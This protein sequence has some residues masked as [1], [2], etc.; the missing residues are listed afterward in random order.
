MSLLAAAIVSALVVAAAI[1]WAGRLVAGEIKASRAAAS[2]ARSLEILTL[3][4]P[5]MLACINDPRTLL[6]WQPLAMTVRRLFPDECATLDAAAGATFPFDTNQLEAAHARW[7]ADW[8][9]WERAHDAE[10]KLKAAA[11]ESEMTVAGATPL[12]RAQLDAVEREKL[13]RY[14]RRYEEYVRTA[15]A[16]QALQAPPAR[17]RL[18]EAADL[19]E[20]AHVLDALL[21]S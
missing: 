13:E 14:Q 11:A 16:L 15:K 7:T 3:L 17:G 18:V 6:V 12:L 1:V 9:A 2:R 19:G 4:T 5:G 21:A 20:C 8:L 10:F